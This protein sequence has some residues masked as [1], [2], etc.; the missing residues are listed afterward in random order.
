M[1]DTVDSWCPSGCKTTVKSKEAPH[2]F[3]AIL[4]KWHASCLHLAVAV[5]SHA[6]WTLKIGKLGMILITHIDGN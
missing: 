3:L 6:S 5:H 1:L 4:A 2:A